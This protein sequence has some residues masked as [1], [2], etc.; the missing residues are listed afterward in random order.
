MVR[1]RRRVLSFLLLSCIVVGTFAVLRSRRAEPVSP[2]SVSIWYWHTPFRVTPAELKELHAM[3][4]AD[5]S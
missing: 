3:G 1:L 2:L 4:V 5:S